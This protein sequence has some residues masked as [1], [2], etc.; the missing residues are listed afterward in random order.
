MEIVLNRK[1]H[2]WIQFVSQKIS[3]YQNK[4]SL[5]KLM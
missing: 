1:Q 5:K 4:E 3:V 2:N